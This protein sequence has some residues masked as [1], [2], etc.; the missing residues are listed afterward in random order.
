[1]MNA[2]ERRAIVPATVITLTIVGYAAWAA[3]RHREPASLV[4][5]TLAVPQESN[6]D[7]KEKKPGRA[8]RVVVPASAKGKT[9]V[10]FDHEGPPPWPRGNCFR[11]PSMTAAEAKKAQEQKKPGPYSWKV[12]NMHAENFEA[13]V[14][15]LGLRTVE[16]QQL[17]GSSCLITDERI[18]REWL[19]EK[20]CRLC[21]RGSVGEELL[22]EH[23]KHF[24]P[25]A[26]P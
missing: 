15:R 7:P 23:A 2:R 26:D 24:G 20:P 9:E 4:G 16:V 5:T 6:S 19:R 17:D 3:Y 8:D 1:M 18:P 22:R 21:F 25:P 13:I 11:V 12:A 14:R 10:G